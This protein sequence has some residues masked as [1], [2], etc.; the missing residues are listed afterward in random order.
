M[1]RHRNVRN[2]EKDWGEYDDGYVPDPT[3]AGPSASASVMNEGG[4]GRG[5]G[6]GVWSIVSKEGSVT[7]ES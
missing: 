6:V 5:D 1:S 4:V 2:L 3:G 7:R